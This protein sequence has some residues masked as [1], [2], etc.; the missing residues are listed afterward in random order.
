M[1]AKQE[2][3]YILNRFNEELKIYDTKT[4]ALI[5]LNAGLIFASVSGLKT[6]QLI[7]YTPCIY[8][9]MFLLCV[10]IFIGFF[11]N[12]PRIHDFFSKKR[13]IDNP[14]LYSFEDV[15]NLTIDAFIDEL[16]KADGFYI[17]TKADN[18]LINIII[19]EARLTN[20]KLDFF[21]ASS[22]M[23]AA[24]SSIGIFSAVVNFF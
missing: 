14:N 22:I 16:K 19:P 11:S 12:F 1:E 3:K 8:I 4:G 23:T 9:G 17:P 7:L 6:L 5:G 13:K 21:R 24:G 10:S 18:D 20:T 2:L 15:S